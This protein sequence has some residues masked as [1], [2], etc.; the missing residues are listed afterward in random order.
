MW[1]DFAA[2][3]SE[4]YR[5]ICPDLPGFG[6][7]PLVSEHISLEEI[8]VI[9]EDWMADIGV[10]NPIVIG[11]SLGG[12]LTLALVELLGDRL[13]GI[14]LLHS[15]AFADDAEKQDSRDKTVLFLRKNGVDKFVTSF[16]PQLFTEDKRNALQ[17]EIELAIDQGRESSLE[18]LIAYTKAMRDRKERFDV[19][20]GYDKPKLMIAGTL[21]TAVKIESSRAQQQA[22][23][24]YIELEGTGHMGMVERKA[25]C[26]VLLKEFCDQIN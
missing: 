23:T 7:S 4:N 2:S 21:D 19:L 18:G 16:V 11:H 10:F 3:L 9:L 5:V 15:T 17:R 14:G 24:H 6:K 22:F 12:Y 26:I 25:E 20:K 13:K 1:T 8:A